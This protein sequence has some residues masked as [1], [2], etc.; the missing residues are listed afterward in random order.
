MDWRAEWFAFDEVAFLNAAGQGPLPRVSA[1]AVQA[2]LEWKKFPHQ[3]PD[4]AY[5]ELPDRVRSSIARL[6]GGKP[7]EV[8]LTTDRKSVV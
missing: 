4:A 1:R 7:D 5:F 8:A 6:A 3:L 2:A